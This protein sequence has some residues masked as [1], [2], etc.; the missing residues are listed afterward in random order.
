[1]LLLA[2]W[3]ATYVYA[4]LNY[5]SSAPAPLEYTH[6]S[7]AGNVLVRV[8]S[9]SIDVRRNIFLARRVSATEP[10]GQVL[11]SL[12]RV[13]VRDAIPW[14]LDRPTRPIDVEATGGFV[15]IDREK[16]GHFRLFDYR[17]ISDE[18]TEPVPYRVRAKDVRIDATDRYGGAVWKRSA[19]VSDLW[20]DGYGE[21]FRASAVADISGSGILHADG[22]SG[23]DGALIFTG[24]A[25]DFDVAPLLRH[26]AETPDAKALPVLKEFSTGSL[27]TDGEF[28]LVLDPGKPTLFEAT[29]DARATNL[30][31]TGEPLA[32]EAHFEGRLTELGALG[33]AQLSW[34]GGAA[35]FDGSADWTDGLVA[36]GELIADAASRES[37]PPLVERQISRDLQFHNGRYEGWIAWK[38]DGLEAQG[39][40][41][42]AWLA[43]RGERVEGPA[44]DVSSG[45]GRI[46]L[47]VERASWAGSPIAGLVTVG[48]KGGELGG[49][50][51]A[52]GL[53][54]R[55]LARRFGITDLMGT[56]DADVLLNGTTSEPRADIRGYGDLVARFENRVFN[57]G[58]VRIDAGVRGDVMTIE[59]ASADG[60][61]GLFLAQGTYGLKSDKLALRVLGNSIP[62]SLAHDELGGIAAFVATVSGTTADPKA[63]GKLELYDAL[64]Q[65]YE[66]PLMVMDFEVDRRRAVSPRLLAVRGAGRLDGSFAY[67]FADGALNGNG[68]ATGISLGEFLGPDYAGSVNAARLY[69]SG[70]VENPHI[71]ADLDGRSLVAKGATIDEFTAE[72]V[73]DGNDV[74]LV[75]AEALVNG[76]A[77]RATGDYSLKTKSGSFDAQGEGLDLSDVVLDLDLLLKGRA[78]AQLRGTYSAD[79]GLDFTGTADLRDVE[80]NGTYIGAGSAEFSATKDTYVGKASLGG[81]DRFIEVPEV[82]Y[83]AGDRDIK[84]DA[85][86][87]N[88]ALQDV[89]AVSRR[90]I[91]KDVLSEELQNKFSTLR[92]NLGAG[93]KVSGAIDNPDVEIADLLVE[94]LQM[95]GTDSGEMRAEATRSDRVWTVDSLTWNGGPGAFSASGTIDE[96][97]EIDLD[98][99]F[100]NLD[101]RWFVSFEPGLGRLKGVGDLSFRVSGKTASPEIDASIAY[102]EGDMG[103]KDRRQLDLLANIVDGK[104]GVEGNYYFE[105]FTG[106]ITAT[107]PFKYPLTVPRDQPLEARLTLPPRPIKELK[108]LLPWLDVDRSEGTVSGDVLVSGTLDAIRTRG[109]VRATGTSLATEGL[110][111]RLTD[112]S[113]EGIFT[114]GGVVFSGTAKDGSDGTVA[115]KDIEFSLDNIGQIP[116]SGV[117]P[118]L[119]NPLS[120]SVELSGFHVAQGG[121]NQATL[122]TAVDGLISLTGT[123]GSP[124]LAGD[125]VA[126]NT[127]FGVGEFPEAGEAAQ[128]FVDPRF[129]INLRVEDRLSLNAGGGNFSLSG[130]GRLG[131]S[132]GQPDLSLD[133]EVERGNLRLPNARVAIDEGGRIAVR[134]RATPYGAPGVQALV[135]L[136]GRTQLSAPGLGD[137]IELYSVT[138]DISGDILQEGGLQITA[139]SDPPG[140]SQDR[141]LTLLGQGEIIAGRPGEYRS[142]SVSEQF[143]AALSI[144]LP[145][146]IGGFTERLGTTLGLDYLGLEYGGSNLLTV[147]FAKA[148]GRYLMLTA[149][150]QI[151]DPLPGFRQKFDIRLSYRLPVRNRFLNRLSFSIG[152]DQDRPWKLSV[153]Y[154]IRF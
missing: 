73:L 25:K 69:V 40:A 81:L 132:L 127:V 90:Y 8:D 44:F 129:A 36:A 21:D 13:E 7:A 52:K 63:I 119:Q 22:R 50:L 138:L 24:S 14:P 115:L 114:E 80:V 91:G 66:L 47:K 153:E 93:V 135:N 19:N 105:G 74:R 154:G 11:A 53:N 124:L 10:N 43:L 98:G 1:M 136:T 9:W 49:R 147:S 143:R 46:V 89:Y 100:N 148:I 32:D 31:V 23:P 16:D 85:F 75:S 106:P 130:G 72:A 95:E 42:G 101:P 79:A 108:D 61:S 139:Q 4:C 113:L 84:L 33:K 62:A 103:D 2:L 41:T 77:V 97:G 68:A 15:R 87:H 152:V 51:T 146:V 71:E 145:Y 94:D 150:K 149:R 133:F 29:L 137:N 107:L 70:T 88:I 118:F 17:P 112:Y 67:R 20:V 60:P 125:L 65:S 144:A 18:P 26:I 39:K 6:V 111:S 122:S 96:H 99:E 109:S 102:R 64:I 123:L 3:G 59:R 78:S 151:S 27:R 56:A 92:G 76:G 82:V 134:Y 141:I 142:V 116:S 140:L 104:V 48:R 37:L 12:D 126:K 34:R 131:G 55:A 83:R 121:T 128:L 117:Q 110:R 28:R 86:L 45:A 30:V 38:N 35:S 58:N 120:G 54:V 5:L 57:L